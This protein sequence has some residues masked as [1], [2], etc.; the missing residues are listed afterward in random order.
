ME[1]TKVNDKYKKGPDNAEPL[2]KNAILENQ[3]SNTGNNRK[4]NQRT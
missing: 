3:M 1:I 4:R 2:L